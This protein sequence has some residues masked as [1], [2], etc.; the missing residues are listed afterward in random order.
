M[1]I[2]LTIG[3]IIHHTAGASSDH[4]PKGENDPDSQIE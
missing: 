4:D 1:F 2:E 3:Q